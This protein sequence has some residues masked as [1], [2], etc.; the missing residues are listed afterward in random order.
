MGRP[1]NN[2]LADFENWM[3]LNGIAN[4]LSTSSYASLIRKILELDTLDLDS[5]QAHV[6]AQNPRTAVMVRSAWRRFVQYART[7]NV[8]LPNPFGEG[9]APKFQK[10]TWQEKTAQFAGNAEM[11]AAPV[12]QTVQTV[13][14]PVS[15]IPP[16]IVEALRNWCLKNPGVAEVLHRLKWEWTRRVA[17]ARDYPITAHPGMRETW[18]PMTHELLDVLG[19]WAYGDKDPEEG[20]L[21]P[22]ESGS[23]EPFPAPLLRRLIGA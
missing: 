2:D 18:I 14:T 10:P 22:K 15:P 8:H 12:A 1:R 21:I 19:E 11:A 7:K 16:H 23:V 4:E 20:Y 17:P 5:L 6:N 3:I 13:Q 9:N